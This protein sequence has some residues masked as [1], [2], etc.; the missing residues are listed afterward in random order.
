MTKIKIGEIF[1]TARPYSRDIK[2]IDG[3][4]NHFYVTSSTQ[5][6]KLALL[7]SGINPIAAVFADNGPRVPAILIRSSPHKVGSQDTPW[8]D[9][10]DVDNGHIHYFGDNKSPDSAGHES[11]GNEALIKACEKIRA[12]DS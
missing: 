4:K 11:K 10:F 9:T 3:F 2:E 8:K 5:S 12:C 6:H 1:R 7:D